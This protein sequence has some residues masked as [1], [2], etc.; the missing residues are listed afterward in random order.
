MAAIFFSK[1]SS[2]LRPDNEPLS[3][4]PIIRYPFFLECGKSFANAHMASQNLSMFPVETVFSTRYVSVLPNN[5]CNSSFVII[6]LFYL[7]MLV[8]QIPDQVGDDD[9][10][11]WA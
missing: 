10:E 9:H 11:A 5:S 7:L 2:T 4:T 6:V 1:E 3:L 8:L